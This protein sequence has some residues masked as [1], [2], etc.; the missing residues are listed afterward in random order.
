M[1]YCLPIIKNTKQEVRKMIEDSRADYQFFEVWLDYIQDLDDEF[2]KSLEESL[3][4]N[5]ILLFRRQNLE[6]IKMD[7][8][9]RT[10]ILYLLNNTAVLIDLDIIGQTEELGFIQDNKLN[11]KVITSYHNYKTTPTDESL[12][13]IIE[14]MNIRSPYTYKVATMCEVEEDAVR[15]LQLLVNLKKENKKFI[16]LGMGENGKITRIFGTL[17]GNEMIFAP[18]NLGE[19]SAPGQLTREQLEEVFDRISVKR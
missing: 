1:N 3:Q 14:T 17:W 10:E 2:I 6:P 18:K 15:L 12:N 19:K 16:V 5:V 11:I 4:G 8:Q 7:F 13:K 9:K